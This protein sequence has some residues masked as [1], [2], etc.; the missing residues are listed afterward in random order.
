ML[1]PCASLDEE[2]GDSAGNEQSCTG[3]EG[4]VSHAVVHVREVPQIVSDNP[5]PQHIGPDHVLFFITRD[6]DS[7]PATDRQQVEQTGD[8]V[9]VVPGA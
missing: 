1:E 4:V 3:I 8:T 5:E 9:H 7:K 2:G 6:K